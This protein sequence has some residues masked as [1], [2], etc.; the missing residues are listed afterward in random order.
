VLDFVDIENRACYNSVVADDPM[1]KTVPPARQQKMKELFCL[2]EGEN[3]IEIIF[4]QKSQPKLP[5]SITVSIDSG[6]Y[7]VPVLKYTKNPDI[8]AKGIFKIYTDA[9]AGFTTVILQ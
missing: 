2:K 7:K 9:P 3:T 1:I 6:N 4:S 5:S 8:K